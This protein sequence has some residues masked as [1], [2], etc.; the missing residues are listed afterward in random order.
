MFGGLI[1]GN[2]SVG[3]DIVRNRGALQEARAMIAL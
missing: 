2:C 1:R 3:W